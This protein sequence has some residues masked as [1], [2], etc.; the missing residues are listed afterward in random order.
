[1]KTSQIET[2]TLDYKNF[3]SYTKDLKK[4]DYKFDEKQAAKKGFQEQYEG[5]KQN[6]FNSGLP[7]AR[8]RKPIYIK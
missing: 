1:M 5:D 6:S 8:G 7:R 2:S 3:G 4:R